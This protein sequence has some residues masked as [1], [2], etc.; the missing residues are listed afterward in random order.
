MNQEKIIELINKIRKYGDKGAYNTLAEW[1]NQ[2]K[3][4]MLPGVVKSLGKSLVC[5]RKYLICSPNS[6]YALKKQLLQKI[7]SLE[8]LLA[9]MRVYK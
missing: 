2:E 6:K 4:N 9:R 1:F 5:A 3:G 7:D 8:R